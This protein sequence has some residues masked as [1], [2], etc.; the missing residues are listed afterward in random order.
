MLIELS[1]SANTAAKKPLS[2]LEELEKLLR[3]AQDRY[4]QYGTDYYARRVSVLQH[5]IRALKHSQNAN[6]PDQA[7]RKAVFQRLQQ[8]LRRW[9]DERQKVVSR[10]DS[11]NLEITKIQT[12][13]AKL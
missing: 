7:A 8:E 3:V 12:Q 5:Q 13:L 10:L 1:L 11:I 6:K 9:L 2:E 4:D